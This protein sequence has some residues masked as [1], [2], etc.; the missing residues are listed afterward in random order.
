[1][2]IYTFTAWSGLSPHYISVSHGHD[3][4]CYIDD[5]LVTGSSNKEHLERLEEVLKRLKEYGLRVKKSK[6]D[7]FQSLVKYLGH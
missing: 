1:M 6:C 4:A 7:F 5:I 2:P 3:F